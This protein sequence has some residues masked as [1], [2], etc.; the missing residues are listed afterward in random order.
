[1]P[2]RKSIPKE[3]T[4]TGAF[5][6]WLLALYG[7][8]SL[9][10]GKD[11]ADFASELNVTNAALTN[12]FD[13]HSE[14]T[15]KG[16]VS[17]IVGRLVDITG[18]RDLYRQACNVLPTLN[19]DP[20][21]LEVRYS[22]SEMDRKTR[23]GFLFHIE[24]MV[25]SSGRETSLGVKV[26]QISALLDP[27]AQMDNCGNDNDP[28]SMGDIAVPGEII[29]LMYDLLRLGAF[30]EKYTRDEIES[31]QDRMLVLRAFSQILSR[32]GLKRERAEI[33]AAINGN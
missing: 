26:R 17:G 22:Y 25:V 1:M 28:N 2:P 12:W 20:A 5:A 30:W 29:S 27:D 21:Y 33:E 31:I 32:K 3:T 14:P 8:W 4:Q 6:T 18:D 24:T 15:C 13:G 23:Y 16:T 7:D 11:Q 19:L 10:T 9:S